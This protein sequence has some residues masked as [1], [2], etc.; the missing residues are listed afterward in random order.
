VPHPTSRWT[1]GS[2]RCSAHPR[3]AGDTH[4]SEHE[5]SRIRRT[6]TPRCEVLL[7]TVVSDIVMGFG[8]G[9]GVNPRARALRFGAL[10]LVLLAGVVFHHSGSTYETIRVAYYIV[11]ASFIFYAIRGRRGNQSRMGVGGWPFQNGASGGIKSGSPPEAW[12][13]PI[14]ARIIETDARTPNE[15]ATPDSP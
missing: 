10:A 1:D 8:I 4:R 11:I 9:R 15:E 14:D 7:V 5:H 13:S 2:I 6:P 12:P 3:T